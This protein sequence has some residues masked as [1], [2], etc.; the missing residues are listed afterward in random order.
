MPMPFSILAETFEKLERTTSRTQ[1]VLYL[2]DLSRRRPPRPSTK[3]CTSSRVS[4]GR[5]GRGYPS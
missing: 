1:M 3:W 5:T 2:V 4:Y